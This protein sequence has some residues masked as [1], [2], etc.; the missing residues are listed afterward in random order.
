M[1]SGSVDPGS[2]PGMTERL[3]GVRLIGVRS[4]LFGCSGVD[5]CNVVKFLTEIV[6]LR[7]DFQRVLS[8]LNKSL[9]CFKQH[10]LLLVQCIEVGGD[11]LVVGFVVVG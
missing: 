6:A 11:K 8:V 1:S 7:R 5:L 3:I 2:G 10:A 9:G 4:R